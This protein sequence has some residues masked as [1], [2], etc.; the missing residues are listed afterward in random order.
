MD[1]KICT[2]CKRVLAFS[3]FQ[4][5]PKKPFGLTA[6]CRDCTREYKR[7]NRERQLKTHYERIASKPEIKPQRSAWNALYYALRIGKISKPD[8]CSVCSEQVGGDK[9]QS[10]HEDYTKPL[11][12]IWCCQDCHVG[13]DKARREVEYVGS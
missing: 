3:Q 7:A 9:I 6:H 5:E 8:T 12:V 13:L 2:R 10:H 1:T 11:D 4:S